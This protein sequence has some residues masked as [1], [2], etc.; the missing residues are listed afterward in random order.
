[1]NAIGYSPQRSHIELN[2]RD[3]L[4]RYVKAIGAQRRALVDVI[5]AEDLSMRRTYIRYTEKKTPFNV[6][7]RETFALGAIMIS[8]YGLMG[9][10]E[11]AIF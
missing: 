11:T 8:H 5:E 4:H 9:I 10:L 3:L 1:M 2:G 7:S 6:I